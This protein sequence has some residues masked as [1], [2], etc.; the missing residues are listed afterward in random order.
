MTDNERKVWETAIESF[1]DPLDP[2]KFDENL[3]LETAFKLSHPDKIGLMAELEDAFD[4]PVN[5]DA[6]DDIAGL[7]LAGVPWIVKDLAKYLQRKKKEA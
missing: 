4:I 6:R 5:D 1:G 2:I 3:N 7:S